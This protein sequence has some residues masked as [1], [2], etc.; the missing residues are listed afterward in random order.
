MATNN[1]T[2]TSNP[3]TVPQGGTGIATTTA[4]AV[5]CG[6][7]TSTGQLQ[8]VSGLGSSGNVLTS[9]GAGALPTWQPAGGGGGGVTTIDGDTGSATGSTITFDA[10]SN[11]GATVNFSASAST[12]NLNVTDGDNNT[13]IGAAS[14]SGG[15]TTSTDNTGLGFGC[16]SSP[17]SSA[18]RNCAFGAGAG[19]TLTSGSDNTLIGYSV[20]N[21]LDSGSANIIIGS[22]SGLA[23]TDSNAIIIGTNIVGSFDNTTVIGPIATGTQTVYIGGVS[24]TVVTGS[25]VLVD[26]SD[27]IGVAVSSRRYK[28][29]INDMGDISSNILKLRPVSFKYIVGSDDSMQTGLIAE[30]V[31]EIMPSLCNYD[32]E[33]LIQSVKYHDLPALLLNELK[34]AVKRIE[35]LEEK[36]ISK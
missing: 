9:S 12:V 4:Y 2:N 33:G 15:I 21:L 31:E 27:K 26:G 8:T 20:G 19:G 11:S 1:A 22:G 25:T 36:L 3:I 34:K 32:K 28:D 7:T 17:L 10:N 5:V 18:S 35:V 14:G 30:E 29:N 24:S 13:F 16:L 6:G 23:A